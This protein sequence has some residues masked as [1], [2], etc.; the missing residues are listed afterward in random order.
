MKKPVK[1][2]VIALVV[3][4]ALSMAKDMIIKTTVEGAVR[5]VT[6]LRL[7]MSGFRVGLINTLVDIRN[8]RL[9]NPAGYKDRTMLNMPEIYVHY[10]LPAIIG[11]KVHLQDVRINLKEF[12]VVKNEK[13]RLNLDSL[14]VV[15]AQKKGNAASQRQDMKAPPIQIDS[16]E[17]KIGKV[18]YKDYSGGRQEPA[19]SE[20]DINLNEKYSNITNPYTLVS[21]IVVKA[22]MNTT[23]AG[24][25]GFDL[26]GLQGSIG[27]TLANAQKITGEA[28]EKAK[29]VATQAEGAAK[30]AAET[31]Q[32]V[33]NVFKNPFGGK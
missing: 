22:L 21:L 14:K 20:F 6:G 15:Q 9:F 8:L 27:D 33:T 10:D 18:L 16:L 19:I 17:L 1:I 23:I 26:H 7:N 32:T 13:G 25:A 29:Q 11:G 24:L 5:V 4:I 30:Q 31:A 2:A 12:V 28:S 3:L